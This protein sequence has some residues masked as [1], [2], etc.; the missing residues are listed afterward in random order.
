MAEPSARWIKA[1]WGRR[2]DGVPVGCWSEVIGGLGFELRG[3]LRL[4]AGGLKGLA[5]TSP[6]VLLGF[7]GP[8]KQ[9]P[10]LWRGVVG[11]AVDGGVEPLGFLRRS[12][13][14]QNLLGLSSIALAT[15]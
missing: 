14:R 3:R 9:T 2:S 5:E 15:Q 6:C 1:V 8:G 13:R 4:R 7:G 12:D 11:S 10:A